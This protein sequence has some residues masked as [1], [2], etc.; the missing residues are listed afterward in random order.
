MGV[1]CQ[2]ML[3]EAGCQAM[4]VGADINPA[5]CRVSSR[6]ATH[7]AVA[8][9]DF[10]CCDMLSSM[11]RRLQVR[12]GAGGGEARRR[13]DAR[14]GRVDVLVFNPPYVPTPS[15]E[16]ASSAIASTWAGGVDGREVTDRLLPMVEVCARLRMRACCARSRARAVAAESRRLA[17]PAAGGREQ[18]RG[19]EGHSGEAGAGGGGGRGRGW[20]GGEL[21]TSRHTQFALVKRARNERQCVLRATKRPRTTP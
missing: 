15:E 18:A 8:F 4:L 11:R 6:T 14:Q 3:A 9:H 2:R 1:Y 17:V 10:V 7:N 19:G 12:G 20:G 13:A 5:A 21:R 16:V